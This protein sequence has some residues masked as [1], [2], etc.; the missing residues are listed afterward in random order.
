MLLFL[1]FLCQLSKKLPSSSSPLTSD[2]L[3]AF[4]EDDYEPVIRLAK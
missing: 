4:L 2:L 3:E 1:L